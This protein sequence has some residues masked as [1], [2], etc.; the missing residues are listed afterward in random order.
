MPPKHSAA[1]EAAIERKRSRYALDYSH[2]RAKKRENVELAKS[3]RASKRAAEKD[4][5]AGHAP[6]ERPK[7]KKAENDL[8]SL[9]ACI[10][11][12]HLLHAEVQT[13][14]IRHAITSATFLPARNPTTLLPGLVSKHAELLRP[15][16]HS[17][18]LNLLAEGGFWDCN[19]VAV[20]NLEEVSTMVQDAYKP[21]IKHLYLA[22]EPDL[23]VVYS[24]QAVTSVVGR[25]KVGLTELKELESLTIAFLY[26]EAGKKKWE[27][28]NGTGGDE[29]RIMVEALT[30]LEVR[31]R[32]VLLQNLGNGAD[33]GDVVISVED[34]ASGMVGE[35]LELDI[36][37]ELALP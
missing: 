34:D 12:L 25:L 22:H 20:D 5:V 32:V 15:F 6:V 7:S 37:D 29:L 10:E 14:I 19:T 2:Q 13:R 9:F 16:H 21:L 36:G 1:D 23:K 28:A 33:V 24:E 8:A 3:K 31:D 35:L 18:R 27:V 30:R 17:I 11:A 4:A 26:E